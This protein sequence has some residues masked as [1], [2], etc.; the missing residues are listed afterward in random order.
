MSDPADFLKLLALLGRE[1]EPVRIA[2]GNKDEFV[3]TLVKNADLIPAIQLL[4]QRGYDLW[5]EINPSNYA[6]ERGRSSAEHVTRLSTLYADLDFKDNGLGGLDSCLE[7]VEALSNLLGYQPSAIVHTG[8]GIHPYWPV[9]DGEITPDSRDEMMTRLKRWGALVKQVSLAHGG[10]ADSVYDLPRI[11]RVPGSTNFKDGTP[12]ATSIEFMTGIGKVDVAWVDEV[13]NDNQISVEMAEDP[14]RV[15]SPMAGWDWAE[16]DCGFVKRATSE[17]ENS[18]PTARHPWA[19]KWSAMLHG[20]VRYGCLTEDSFYRLRDEVLLHQFQALLGTGSQRS[21][22]PGEWRQI[23]QFGQQRSQSWSKQ[24][25]MEELRHHEHADALANIAVA[26]A[27]PQRVAPVTNLFSGQVMSAAAPT[28]PT[29]GALAL[30]FA[31]HSQRRLE[32]AA[33]TDMGNAEQLANAFQEKAI[34]VPR[35]GWHVWAGG[36]WEPDTSNEVIEIAKDAFLTLLVNQEED[37]AKK[38]MHSSL[39]RSRIMSALELA[40][41]IPGVVI[42]ASVMDSEAFELNTPGGVVDLHTGLVRPASPSRDFHTL[43]TAQTPAA[44]PTPRF[45]AFL[46]YAIEDDERIEYLQR[47]FG[48]AAIGRLIHHVFPIFLGPGANGKTTLLDIIAGVMGQYASVMPA[49][50]L[51]ESRGEHPTVIAQL[52][53][54]RIAINSEVPPSARFDEDLVKQLTGETRLKARLIGEN[55]MEFENMATQFLAANHLPSVPV[56][57]VGFW[58]RVRKIDFEKIVPEE[59]QDP[60]LVRRILTEEG[61]G[62]LQWVIDGAQI[63]LRD[64]LNDP[65]SVKASTLEYQLEEDSMARFLTENTETVP[66]TQVIRGALYARYKDF[67]QRQMLRPLTEPKFVREVSGLRPGSTLGGKAFFTNMQMLNIYSSQQ[68]WTEDRE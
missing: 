3:P 32:N 26:P 18:D 34:F 13:L 25:L 19:L 2:R 31:A 24:K 1:G 38:W 28:A 64:G 23:L 27:P 62:V 21:Q 56:G 10:D 57:G 59:S 30:S 65:A 43:R 9:L 15:V 42:P 61:P 40:K 53:G 6:A 48:L 54:V 36:R 66:G 20:M 67:M 63:V 45:D 49:K 12:R 33:F 44:I 58:R 5:Y 50:F 47:L 52:R 7:V 39:S 46:R 37:A 22:G 14:S 4:A 41:S 29:S 68:T 51:M 35:L 60:L 8:G 16:Q 17:I 55:F 11:L